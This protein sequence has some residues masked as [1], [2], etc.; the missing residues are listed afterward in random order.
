V[1]TAHDPI[2]ALTS[3]YTA[4][5]WNA[6]TGELEQT[7]G[8]GLTGHTLGLTSVAF[9]PD[10]KLVA[11][12]S[13]DDL[14]I[15]WDAADSGQPLTTMVGH[16]ADVTDVAF[17]P[18][19][20]LATAS[21]DGTVRLW[22]AGVR[23]EDKP[24]L[25]SATGHDEGILSVAFSPDGTRLLTGSL[26]KTAILWDVKWDASGKVP[27]LSVSRRVYDH[28]DSIPGVA[29]SPN[30]R[31]FVTAS[32]DRRALVWN[33]ANGQLVRAI[34]GH[35]DGLEG[36]A[37]R[38]GPDDG[39]PEVADAELCGRELATASYDGTARRW[40][41]G[42][43]QELATLL[44]HLAPVESTA[45]S[46][47]GARMLTGGDDG[48]A[49]VWDAASGALLLDLKGRHTGRVNRAIF[50]PDDKYI[51]TA[52]WDGSAGLWDAA[53][54]DWIA[55]FGEQEA[56]ERSTVAEIS[57]FRPQDRMLHG[58]A[59]SPDGKTLVT[60][61]DDGSVET[62]AVP[63][64]EFLDS[65]PVDGRRFFNVLFSPDGSQQLATGLSSALDGLIQIWPP[66]RPEEAS[67]LKH[68][69]EEVYD[70]AFSPDGR[71][72][73]SISWD[74]TAMLWSWPGRDAIRT[75]Q[76]HRDRL[77]GVAFT[78]NGKQLITSSGDQ[79]ARVRDVA[80]GNVVRT[81]HGPELNGLAINKDGK[82]VAI[83][84]EDGT[85]RLYT[86]DPDELFAL[87]KSRVTR[88]LTEAERAQYLGRTQ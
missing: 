86:L 76:G 55:R 35:Q 4:R 60:V 63:G 71:R 65:A 69:D 7:L 27:S 30:G 59:F 40:N 78:P 29:F 49:K 43:T 62:W 12:G 52:S 72:L 32:R 47:D 15:V 46:P 2:D 66:A 57:A 53:T 50:S 41:V 25:A 54:G 5:I 82:T 44:G 67:P 1:A 81:L 22:D 37:F 11:T 18:R 34:V 45:Y 16:Q 14:A 19:G 87:A 79:T 56:G 48:T 13:L 77:Y 8:D 28:T 10:G 39:K 23:G 73:A 88:E 80:T 26:D 68:G 36:A 84:G 74:G 21:R 33:A 17:G 58:L 31:C 51:A 20:L 3:V 83:G 9:S 70:A 75:L 6:Q 64:G 24:E 38:P 42:A 85:V 61:R